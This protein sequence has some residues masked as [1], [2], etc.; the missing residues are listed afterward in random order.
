MT[1]AEFGRT[2][3]RR[4]GAQMQRRRGAIAIAVVV[5]ASIVMACG[6]RSGADGC[7]T[8]AAVNRGVRGMNRQ[9]NASADALEQM[10]CDELEREERSEHQ[11]KDAE[12]NDRESAQTRVRSFPK[13]PELNAT[14][15][16][17]KVICE[18]QGGAF[19]EEGAVLGC[20]VGGP[21]IFAGKT[22]DGR[23]VKVDTYFERGDL[24]AARRNAETMYG[25]PES[26][27]V[28]SEGFRVFLWRAGTVAVTM[29]PKGVRVT[30]AIAE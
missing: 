25:P 14:S 1:S 26:E 30:V 29:Y 10:R 5:M 6:G 15:A 3:R 2:L 22:K 19:V 12:R 23:L 9:Q 20:R 8:Q 24:A 13:A 11:A 21:V 18:S 27:N 7:R 17:A 16:E 28:S 4:E